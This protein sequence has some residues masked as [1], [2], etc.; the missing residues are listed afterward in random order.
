MIASKIISAF[1]TVT[2]LI[3]SLS[4]VYAQNPPTGPPNTENESSSQIAPAVYPIVGGIAVGVVTYLLV[5]KPTPKNAGNEGIETYLLSKNILP[6]KDAINLMYTLN[7]SLPQKGAVPAKTKL[8][9]PD[10]PDPPKNNTAESLTPEA[11]AM[12][13][14]QVNQFDALLKEFNN[15]KAFTGSSGVN[16]QKTTSN[17]SLDERNLKELQAKNFEVS[18]LTAQ[19]VT[20]LLTVLNQTLKTANTSNKI[21]DKETLLIE[22][23][24]ND[25][26]ELLSI[27]YS[28][29]VSGS[30][31]SMKS[32]FQ[33]AERYSFTS[34][35]Y[36]YPIASSYSTAYLMYQNK[37]N[38]PAEAKT[39]K[40][41]AD[42]NFAFSVFKIVSGKAVTKGQEVEGK[43]SVRYVS[44]ALKD[45]KDY[46]HTATGLATYAQA[47]LPPAKFYIEVFDNTKNKKIPLS[48]PVIDTRDAYTS[49]YG[50]YKQSIIVP[51]YITDD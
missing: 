47:N 38:V 28:K 19:L 34:G 39:D 41:N 20:E 1:L 40:K 50:S 4:S 27:S 21:G 29:K 2:L 24:T 15:S 13:V 31:Q 22:N 48:N 23:I 17:L 11:K 26:S 35:K 51:I 45:L 37:S 14:E 18:Y 49:P 12:L 36:K 43:Y 25:L 10:F 42:A 6:T 46:Y 9:Y 33:N 5:K 16:L 30:K 7:P 32:F 3:N 44:P 8:T